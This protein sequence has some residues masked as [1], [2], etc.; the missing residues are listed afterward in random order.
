M[1]KIL[2]S[3]LRFLARRMITR[4]QPVVIGV[5]GSV[6]KTSTKEAIY[7]VLHRNFF[8]RKS[9]GNINNE[10]GIPLAVLG[11]EPSGTRERRAT[12]QTRWRLI[13]GVVRA[14]WQAWG[15][16][17]L[18]FPKI[19]VLEI[20]A[21]RPGDIAYLS[22]MVK[23]QI[24]VI[25]AIGGVPV[26]VEFYPTPQAVA[27]EKAHILDYLGNQGVAVLNADDAI[28]SGLKK[29]VHGRIISFGI[30]HKA[31]IWASDISHYVVHD[32]IEGVSFKIHKGDSFVP[33]RVSGLIAGHQIYSLLAAAAVGVQFGMNL[34]E[35]SSALEAVEPFKHRM[36]LVPG[37]KNTSLIDDTYNA[38]PLSMQAAL[39]ALKDFGQNRR[40]IAVL[41]DMKELGTY[42][43]EAHKKIGKLALASAKVLI[44][45]GEL[46]KDMGGQHVASTAD[47]ILKLKEII[48]EGDV[49][50]V[51]GSRALKMEAIIDALAEKL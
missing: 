10:I 33:V 8:V 30:T 29:Q 19:L 26:H 36:T 11:I 15:P 27:R 4:Y 18:K 39:E 42:S 43:Q 47:A 13:V 48:Q 51:K 46:S 22:E 21:D 23:P 5:T 32:R 25:S 34:V 9:Y 3:I 28:V 2:Q 12:W 17:P 20:G 14:I 44:T 45:I 41:G 16:L 1:R 7:E 31:D 24:A 49:I 37:I 38:S 6:G 35:I 50:L 40:K